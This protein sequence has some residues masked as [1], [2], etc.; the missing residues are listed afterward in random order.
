MRDPETVLWSIAAHHSEPADPDLLD[1]IKGFLDHVF[2]L[3]PWTIV[4]L[5]A[6][7]IVLIPLSIMGVYLVQQRRQAGSRGAVP[8][9]E[10]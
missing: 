1:W 5:L 3:G 9:P 8:G 7:V 2:N 10:D 6:L 4:V